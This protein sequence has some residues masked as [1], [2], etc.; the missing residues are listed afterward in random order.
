MVSG[1]REHIRYDAPGYHVAALLLLPLLD[2]ELLTHN[3]HGDIPAR[4]Q[5][6]IDH[7]DIIRKIPASCSPSFLA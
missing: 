4:C 7:Q 5:H 1:E 6:E 3:H 2:A